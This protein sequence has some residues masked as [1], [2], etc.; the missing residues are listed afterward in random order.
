MIHV[1]KLN[2]KT[3]KMKEI[4]SLVGHQEHA[5]WLEIQW[6]TESM[7][8][9]DHKNMVTLKFFISRLPDLKILINIA[10]QF[11]ENK[12]DYLI[13]H[14]GTNDATTNSFRKILDNLL[15]LRTN[16]A[17]Q[18]RS[19]RIVLSN[20]TVRHDHGKA[21]LTIRNANKQLTGSC[22]YHYLWLKDQYFTGNSEM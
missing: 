1:K 18:L 11:V 12:P 8:S 15:M 5:Q 9:G 14:V 22:I 4:M 6:S 7:Q 19:C 13:R 16:I 10:Y 21:D 2:L 17:K 20:P 3:S